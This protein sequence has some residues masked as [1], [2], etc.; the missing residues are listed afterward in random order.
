MNNAT[1]F[2][3]QPVR[4]ILLLILC[5]S[6]ATPAWAQTPAWQWAQAI[7]PVTLVEKPTADEGSVAGQ[8][9]AVDAL[10]NVYVVGSFIGNARFGTL[11][12]T[13]SESSADVFVA[14]LDPAGQWQWAVRA[15]GTSIDAATGV[16]VDAS[17]SVYIV[18]NFLSPRA[19]FGA[20]T[21]TNTGGSDVFVA[22]LDPAGQWQ[23]AVGAGGVEVERV[24]EI[25][26]DKSGNVLI[27]G[28]FFSPSARFGPMTLTN[29]T[30][31]SLDLFVAKLDPAGQWQWAIRAGG[32]GN[33]SAAGVALDGNNNVFLT[34]EFNSPDVR[35]GATSLAAENGSTDVFV[36][37]LNPEGEWQWA[38]KA[39]GSAGTDVGNSVAVDKSGNVLVTGYFLSPRADFGTTTL[40]SSGSSDVFVAKLN[41]SGQWQW[42]VKAGGLADDRSNCIA[43]DGAGNAVV[44][45][46][47]LSP[48]SLFGLSNL[49]NSGPLGV[50]L[51]VA[52][53]NPE[54]EWQWAAKADGTADDTGR[55]LAVDA[56]GNVLVT[57]YF[58]SPSALF[59]TTALTNSGLYTGFV[60]KLLGGVTTAQTRSTTL[61]WRVFPNPAAES[62][63]IQLA[64]W[65][66]ANLLSLVDSQGRCVRKM[67]LVNQRGPLDI[68][69]RG[70]A[71]GFYLVQVTSTAG[72]ASRR[73]VVQ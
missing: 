2:L 63:T 11:T 60:A 10:G 55:G 59:G 61:E 25:A 13:A 47:F 5:W 37:K 45:G 24:N 20:T 40:T 52:K 27:A 54:G 26:L 69:L 17:G 9:V 62:V 51:F 57:G 50:D 34:G 21:L 46:Y 72:I 65:N 30:L 23:W 28:D 53:L 41:P 70:L 29:N 71:P 33:E 43:V 18:G 66:G 16:A 39:G 8:K 14:K 56:S 48:S 36:A 68:S 58:L 7:S 3:W 1:R 6:L 42:A 38:T 15:G 22:K 4:L 32:T 19:D 67:Q 49:T 31:M 73:L 44:T 35:F 64:N 12:L